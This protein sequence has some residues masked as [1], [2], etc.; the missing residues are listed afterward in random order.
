[1]L[2][3]R[4]FYKNYGLRK[5]EFIGILI[6]RRRGL[7]GKTRLESGLRWARFSFAGLVKDRQAMFVVPN[8]LKLRSVPEWMIE[9]GVFTKEELLGIMDLADQETKRKG[10]GGSSSV[11][12]QR[13]ILREANRGQG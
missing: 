2:Y 12:H 4:V 8:E 3:Y 13:A 10:V 6:E 1:M 5:G 7:R 9:K 11:I